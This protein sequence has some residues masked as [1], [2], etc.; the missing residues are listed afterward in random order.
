[1]VA[2]ASTYSKGDPGTEGYSFSL[3]YIHSK[4]PSPN[5][6]TA[7]LKIVIIFI[8]EFYL[9]AYLGTTCMPAT[10]NCQKRASEPLELKLQIVL[11]RH[12]NAGN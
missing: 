12:V 5:K 2:H 9:H 4:T 1:M 7:N 8:W 11:R 10:Q 6:A 3:D